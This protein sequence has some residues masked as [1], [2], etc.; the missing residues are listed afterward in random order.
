VF[1]GRDAE[2][3]ACSGQEVNCQTDRIKE[4]FGNQACS[5]EAFRQVVDSK[6]RSPQI[7]HP[8]SRHE[9]ALLTARPQLRQGE[10]GAG[11]QAV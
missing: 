9:E 11:F 4:D 6:A 10:S 8:E 5:Q 3:P 2:A 1:D 7:I